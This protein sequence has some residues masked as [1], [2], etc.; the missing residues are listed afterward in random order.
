MSERSSNQLTL[1]VKNAEKYFDM[2]VNMH[3]PQIIN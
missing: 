3:P 2:H 1:S